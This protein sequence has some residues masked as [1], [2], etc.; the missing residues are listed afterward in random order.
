MAA[1]ASQVCHIAKIEIEPGEQRII[2]K[3]LAKRHRLGIIIVIL[4]VGMDRFVM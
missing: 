2:I 4:I 1:A 3:P